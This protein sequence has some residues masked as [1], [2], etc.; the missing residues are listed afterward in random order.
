[1]WGNAYTRVSLSVQSRVRMKTGKN[2][3][4]PWSFIGGALDQPL[5][6]ESSRVKCTYCLSNWSCKR[7]G[8]FIGVVIGR[9][10]Y[11]WPH[12]ATVEN[13]WKPHHWQLSTAAPNTAS[14]IVHNICSIYP[15]NKQQSK[16]IQVIINVSNR[17]LDWLCSGIRPIPNVGECV[18]V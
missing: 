1:M 4:I 15:T 2:K 5:S 17:E 6:R 14:T 12:Y 16:T 11:V 18:S 3:R 8:P 10:L 7:T 9:C 13:Q